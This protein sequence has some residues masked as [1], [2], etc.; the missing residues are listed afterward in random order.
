MPVRFGVLDVLDASE[1]TPLALLGRPAYARIQRGNLGHGLCSFSFSWQ[2]H[3][4]RRIQFTI[5]KEIMEAR[6]ALGRKVVMKVEMD[7]NHGQVINV[8]ML[9]DTKEGRTAVPLVTY[10][11]F[12][13][14]K[15]QYTSAAKQ[16]ICVR[17]NLAGLDISSYYDR[18]IG[19]PVEGRW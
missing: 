19:Q 12:P 5:P 3:K 8:Y 18:G 13:G 15:R 16:G 14:R 7:R 17:T 4:S 9:D 1:G 10:K 11:Y 6:Q 2:G